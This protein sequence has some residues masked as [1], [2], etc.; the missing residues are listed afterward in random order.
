MVKNGSDDR[1]QKLERHKKSIFFDVRKQK[2]GQTQ[3][4]RSRK[5]R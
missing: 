2:R 3:Q 1:G 4:L 5:G